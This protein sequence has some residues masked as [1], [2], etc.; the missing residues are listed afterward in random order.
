MKTRST[1]VCTALLLAC[2]GAYLTFAETAKNAAAKL[3]PDELKA[4][5]RMDSAPLPTGGQM[6][7]S[8]AGV[9]EK[10]IPSVVRI[11]P[12][13]RVGGGMGGQ[14]RGLNELHPEFR[15]FF[16]RFYGLPEGE[17]FGMGEDE[18]EGDDERQPRRRQQ[19]P[20]GPIQKGTGS[21]VVITADGYI[22]TN[23][24]V[25]ED[26]E[27]I[28]VNVGNNSKIYEAKVVG[29]D[30]RT[31]V[32][33]IKIEAKDLPFATLGDSTKLRVGDVV[34]AA[35]SPMELSQSVTLG[36]VSAMGRT[37][38]G[39]PSAN[40]KLVGL[41]DFIQTDA[42][43]NPGNSGGPLLDA[44]GRV[45]GIN[46]AILSRSGMNA[47]IGFSIPI[48]LALSIVEDLVDDGQVTRGYLGVKMGAVR[49]GLGKVLGLESD[50]GVWID[51]VTQ[52]SPAEK[53]G[54]EPGDVILSA[55]GQN[56]EDGTALS[57][58]VGVSKPGTKL[59][60]EVFRDGK[61][62]TLTPT[63]EAISD[64]ELASGGKRPGSS[65]T[66]NA[67]KEQIRKASP[68]EL[69]PGCTV[70]DLTPGLRQRYSVDEQVNGLIV[71]NVEANSAASGA[72][73]EEG[74]VITSINNTRVSTMA[75]VRALDKMGKEPI[76]L[77]IIRNGKKDAI[78]IPG[79]EE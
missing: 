60:L 68:T 12:S 67:G 38:I 52:G 21:G 40:S 72:G 64:E 8:Y 63:L 9:V 74:D 15:E 24:H 36:I 69:L 10:I 33:L 39:L 6:Q 46:T 73:L 2:G 44:T 26:A 14:G 3:K 71:L 76:F 51:D 27:K 32:A 56:L 65:T 25:I 45:I 35:G 62:I 78:I 20:Q 1:A 5:L 31:D 41:Q 28:E 75:D 11:T 19:R 61:R 50:A 47:G 58:V 17:D 16:R 79:S 13:V 23:N 7:M 66:A 57:R 42:S 59:P 34:L 37:G 53:A 22:L 30:P 29:A 18:Q 4:K 77:R 55:G 43:I 48:N 70:Q 49:E 54:L